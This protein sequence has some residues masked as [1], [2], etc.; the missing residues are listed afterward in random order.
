MDLVN[1]RGDWPQGAVKQS[2]IKEERQAALSVAD[3]YLADLAALLTGGCR[4]T[5]KVCQ[6]ATLSVF[7]H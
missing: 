4:A 7:D 1:T 3:G 6:R 5:V 2:T